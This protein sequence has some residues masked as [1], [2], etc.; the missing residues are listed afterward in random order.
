MTNSALIIAFHF[1]PAAGSSG[2]HR[3][4]AMANY[5]PKFGWQPI[6]LTASI[7]AHLSVSDQILNHLDRSVVVRRSHAFDAARHL[8]IAGKYPDFIAWPDRWS[9]WWPSAVLAGL[10]LI[11]CHR[12]KLIWSTYPIATA[13]LIGSTLQRLSGLPWVADFRDSMTDEYFPQDKARKCIFKW[14]DWEYCQIRAAATLCFR[15]CRNDG[16]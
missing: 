10:N 4:H 8:S 1:P 9:T 7:K 14:I 5:L 12:P 11:R 16:C 3:A 6:V 13:H 15:T 2:V